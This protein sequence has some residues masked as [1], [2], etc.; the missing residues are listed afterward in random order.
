MNWSNLPSDLEV[1]TAIPPGVVVRIADPGGGDPLRLVVATDPLTQDPL[2][3][4]TV[5]IEVG[6]TP[7]GVVSDSC[8]LTVACVAGEAIAT[9]GNQTLLTWDSQG[10]LIEATAALA[11]AGGL[12]RTIGRAATTFDAA[13]RI[14]RAYV[15]PSALAVSAPPE[16]GDDN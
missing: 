2:G 16:E 15:S 5:R 9:L 8:G 4:S 10:R 1:P 13:G 7:Q 11:P 12:L 3:V 6:A 14:C